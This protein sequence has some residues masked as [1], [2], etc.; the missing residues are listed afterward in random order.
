LCRLQYQKTRIY[1]MY[2]RLHDTIRVARGVERE[3]LS[4]NLGLHQTISEL[5]QTLEDNTLEQDICEEDRILKFLNDQNLLWEMPVEFALKPRDTPLEIMEEFQLDQELSNRIRHI[6]NAFQNL[7]EESIYHDNFKHYVEY[8]VSV[9][10]RIDRVYDE[11]VE[12]AVH[13]KLRLNG[14]E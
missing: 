7:F 13:A 12:K 11:L 6:R 14:A 9:L 5:Q 10:K 8:T 1:E 2:S 4:I 3:I